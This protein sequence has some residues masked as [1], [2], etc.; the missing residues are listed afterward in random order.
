[1]QN[2]DAETAQKEK[3]A[4]H[5]GLRVAGFAFAKSGFHEGFGHRG[6]R[7]KI[8]TCHTFKPLE[9]EKSTG[10]DILHSALFTSCH[11]S[12]HDTFLP[13]LFSINVVMSH[14]SNWTSAKRKTPGP[15][16]GGNSYP[17][18]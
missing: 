15:G 10:P 18:S 13:N 16:R 8:A 11:D 4:E 14:D 3:E 2:E 5:A 6:V 9:K 12:S 7:V 17:L 1:M